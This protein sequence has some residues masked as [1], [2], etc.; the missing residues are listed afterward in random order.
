MRLL[1]CRSFLTAAGLPLAALTFHAVQR[2]GNVLIDVSWYCGTCIA[3]LADLAARRSR[4]TR[5]DGN[6]LD[7]D[8]CSSTCQFQNLPP[9]SIMP[10][11]PPPPPTNGRDVDYCYAGGL[12]S[13]PPCLGEIVATA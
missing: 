4:F 9:P 8:G 6:V 12:A 3:F 10:S 11:P 7:G 5:S 13:C 2:S 1:D